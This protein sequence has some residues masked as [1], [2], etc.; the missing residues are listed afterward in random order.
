MATIKKV[1]GEK[2]MS[3]EEMFEELGYKKRSANEW[4]IIY[5]KSIPENSIWNDYFIIDFLISKQVE[6]CEVEKRD[7]SGHSVPITFKELQAINKQLEE[8][9]KKPKE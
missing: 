8:L 6:K 4:D 5:K 1:N 7:S 2:K 3:V 9:D